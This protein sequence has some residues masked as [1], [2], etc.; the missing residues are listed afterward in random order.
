M[1]WEWAREKVDTKDEAWA[2]AR[3]S[4]KGYK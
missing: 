2:A 4:E 3:A 1:E